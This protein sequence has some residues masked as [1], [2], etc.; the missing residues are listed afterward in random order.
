MLSE[1]SSYQCLCCMPRMRGENQCAL[2][3][4]MTQAGE[5]FLGGGV[6]RIEGS[7]ESEAAA[8]SSRALLDWLPQDLGGELCVFLLFFLCS[9]KLS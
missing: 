1:N 5:T 9:G 7:G 8:P 2:Q 6:G 4:D 3:A